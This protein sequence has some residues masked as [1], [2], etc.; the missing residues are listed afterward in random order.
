MEDL[1]TTY[2]DPS[3]GMASIAIIYDLPDE[4]LFRDFINVLNST[5]D[6]IAVSSAIDSDED[7]PSEF[8]AADLASVLRDF[9]RDNTII[10][11]A[12]Y[13]SP[14][15]IILA[16]EA[17]AASTATTIL[18]LASRFAKAKSALAGSRV[19]WARANTE[20]MIEENKQA[21]LEIIHERIRESGHKNME[22]RIEDEPFG[23]VTNNAAYALAAIDEVRMLD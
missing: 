13:N 1:V 17:A 10:R 8:S 20:V 15:E 16:I 22:G 21:A 11:R 5:L 14:L 6:L 2:A 19:D 9:A 4:I 7:A 18:L 3:V 12:S 23:D